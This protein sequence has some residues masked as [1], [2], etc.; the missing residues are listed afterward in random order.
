MNKASAIKM[1]DS[2][3]I[4]GLVKPKTVKIGINS[5]PAGNTAIKVTA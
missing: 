4:P 5:F 2:G 1:V 3:L